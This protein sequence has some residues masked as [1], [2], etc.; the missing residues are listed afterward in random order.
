MA[1]LGPRPPPD[2][3]VHLL[4]EAFHGDGHDVQVVA[5]LRHPAFR[6]L[7]AVADHRDALD[8]Q[9]LLA[10][11]HHLPQVVAALDEERFS[12]GEIDLLHASLGQHVQA[13]LGLS[14]G[15]QEGRLRCVKTETAWRIKFNIFLLFIILEKLTLIV[16]LASKMKVDALR[17]DNLCRGLAQ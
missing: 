15:Q 7:A 8:V 12:A 4:V 16:A 9:V 10:V 2:L 1:G 6:H 14:Q 11:P 17:N 13:P 5:V 3:L